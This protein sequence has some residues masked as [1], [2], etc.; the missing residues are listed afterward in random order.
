MFK[1]DR[2]VAFR[3]CHANDDVPEHL[4]GTAAYYRHNAMV[5]RRYAGLPL[6]PAE[7]IVCVKAAQAFEMLAAE[8]A[9]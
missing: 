2:L 1:P 7:H 8:A 9:S 3:T 5:F 6:N 4:R